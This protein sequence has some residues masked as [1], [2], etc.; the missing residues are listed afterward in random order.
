MDLFNKDTI[1]IK[2]S[3]IVLC[4]IYSLI[5]F[6]MYIVLALSFTAAADYFLLVKDAD[7][8][9]GVSLFVV[10]QIIYLLY[11]HNN[12]CR[13]YI[14]YRIL[15]SLL[16]LIIFKVFKQFNMLNGV[17]AIYFIELI[18]N[19]ISSLSNKQFKWLSVGFCLF[20]MCDICV[21]LFNILSPGKLFDAVSLLMWAFY[22]P[23]QVLIAIHRNI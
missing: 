5:N 14:G 10:A 11:L 3:G 15:I 7:Y 23:S 16:V 2:Y 19:F 8:L 22:L 13:T 17:A 12:E 18:F 4:L 1:L 6:D 21:G 9:L 20:I